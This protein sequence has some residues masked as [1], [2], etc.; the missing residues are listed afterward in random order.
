[1]S[2]RVSSRTCWT[3]AAQSAKRCPSSVSKSIGSYGATRPA[4]EID[5]SRRIRSTGR[6]LIL[7]VLRNEN[8]RP[9]GRTADQLA[10]LRAH[11]RTPVRRQPH[12]LVLVFVH[13]ESEVG[14]ERGVEH[15]ERVREPDLTLKGDVGGSVR[16]ALA[17]AGRECRPFADAVRGQD[18]G[19]RRRGREERRGRVRG[20]VSGKQDLRA[21]DVEVRRNDAAHPDLLAE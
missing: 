13:G 14:G 19:A 15:A 8:E 17:M 7:E 4:E 2:T 6:R 3:L 9:V 21:R 16:P 20:V 5:E 18:R 1:M 11:G 12:H 10:D